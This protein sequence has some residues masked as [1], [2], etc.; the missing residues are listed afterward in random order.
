MCESKH[1]PNDGSDRNHDAGP[2]ASPK[3]ERESTRGLLVFD[4]LSTEF[5][6]NF[7][8]FAHLSLLPTLF[9]MPEADIRFIHGTAPLATLPHRRDCTLVATDSASLI[10]SHFQVPPFWI[11]ASACLMSAPLV[12][13]PGVL[14]V[15]VLAAYGL[16][17]LFPIA[18]AVYDRWSR[19]RISQCTGGS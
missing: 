1:T 8:N 6:A 9:W 16:T 13:W 10:G 14:R 11:L 7:C 15:G 19:G 18:G 4:C 3:P 2:E 5:T 12:R 17:L